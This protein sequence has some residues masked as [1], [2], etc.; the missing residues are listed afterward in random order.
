MQYGNTL[1]RMTKKIKKR[2]DYYAKLEKQIDRQ[3]NMYKN[4][5]TMQIN[6]IFGCGSNS[7]N[8]NGL[9]AGAGVGF[10]E[11]QQKCISE[12]AAKITA[13]P[14]LVALYMSNPTAFSQVDTNE[15]KN[16]DGKEVKVYKY[17]VTGKEGL[18]LEAEEFD[19]IRKAA[20]LAQYGQNQ[21]GQMAS[22]WKNEYEN[23]I[24]TWIEAQ[25]EELAM[26]K[27]WELDLLEEEQSDME[28]EKDTIETQLKMAEERKKQIE[29]RLDQSIQDSAPK[30]GIG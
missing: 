13:D 4:Q 23:N 14:E 6:S 10:S 20:Q 18:E 22:Q 24:N 3:G 11:I 17:T 27:E 9:F 19:K 1:D 29:Q 28:A 8:P 12:A 16:V 26:Q 2:Q 7:W 5:A 21:Y 30:F 15:T 25:K